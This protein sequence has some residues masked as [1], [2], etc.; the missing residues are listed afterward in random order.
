MIT[1]RIHDATLWVD[2]SDKDS[3]DLRPL[4]HRTMNLLEAHGWTITKDPN[5]EKNYKSLSDSHRLGQNGDLHVAME[6]HRAR[7]EFKFWQELVIQPGRKNGG[8]YSFDQRKLMPYLIRLQWQK[9]VYLITNLWQGECI[10]RDSKNAIDET[11]MVGMAAVMKRMRQWKWHTPKDYDPFTFTSPS[12]YNVTTCDGATIQPG[13]WYAFYYHRRLFRGQA[14][15][16]LN[17]NWLMLMNENTAPVCVHTGHIWTLKPGLPRREPLSPRDQVS[18]AE[19]RLAELI[20]KQDFEKCIRARDHL[21][22]LKA[23]A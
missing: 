12:H 14:F 13:R 16:S 21:K 22:R 3:T 15:Y 10:S 11:P 6:C 9:T 17:S 4:W 1:F 7:L 19:S 2:R 23:A 20:Q 5:I 18:K 8:R